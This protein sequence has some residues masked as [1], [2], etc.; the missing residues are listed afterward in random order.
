MMYEHK[1]KIKRFTNRYL[2]VT[3][4]KCRSR[5]ELD[6]RV[7]ASNFTVRATTADSASSVTVSV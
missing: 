6:P 2:I 1:N 5:G 4:S 7:Y 3:Q